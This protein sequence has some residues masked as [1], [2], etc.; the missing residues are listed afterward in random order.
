VTFL[1]LAVLAIALAGMQLVGERHVLTA[2]LLFLPTQGW[3]L[4]ACLLLPVSLIWDRLLGLLLTVS[5]AGFVLGYLRPEFNDWL[6]REE[7][8]VTV[9]SCNLGHNRV[10]DLGA[11]IAREDPDLIAIQEVN[12]RLDEI[13]RAFPEYRIEGVDQFPLLSRY[14]ILDAKVVEAT[15]LHGREPCAARFELDYRGRR[16]AVY[17][18]H[19][20]TPRAMLDEVW[21]RPTLLI[22]EA[23]GGTDG[24]RSAA[25]TAGWR[26]QGSQIDELVA[27]L[28]AEPLPMLVVGDFNMAAHGVNYPKLRS[29]LMDAFRAR[30]RRFGQTFP[31]DRSPPLS[32]IAPWS[33]LDYQFADRH[34]SICYFDLENGRKAQHRATVARYR[35][36]VTP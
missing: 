14:P 10:A 27:V 1:Y 22:S 15:T 29:L 28:E 16:I 34:W 20:Q 25:L 32:Y 21:R 4:P 31:C 19:M 26:N 30:G 12:G 3:I 35:L 23:F 7:G 8:D 18:V 11:F 17:N 2:S 36:K 5:I 33:R 6:P 9:V 24:G 13:A